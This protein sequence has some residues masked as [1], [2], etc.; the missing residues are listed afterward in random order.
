MSEGLLLQRG[1]AV[2]IAVPAPS[3][4]L[5]VRGR[6]TADPMQAAPKQRQSEGLFSSHDCVG[7]MSTIKP[8]ASRLCVLNNVCLD[9]SSG[10][11]NYYRD[12]QATQAPIVFDRRYGHIFAFGHVAP[13][14]GREDLL[15]LN[16]HVRYKRHVRW[17]PRI[18]DGPL[19][20]GAQHL[21]PLHLLS[22]PFVSTNLGHLAWE[23]AF[24]LLLGMAQLGIYEEAP[25]ILRTHDCNESLAASTHEGYSGRRQIRDVSNGPTASEAKL[26][27]KFLEGFMKPL[28][29]VRTVG[30]VRAEYTAAGT[31]HV[32]FTRLMAGGYYDMFNA[33]AHAGKEPWLQLYRQRVL[34]HH[35]L[36]PPRGLPPPPSTHSLLLV[37]KDGRRGIHNYDEVLD[38]IRHGCGGVCTGIPRTVPVAFHTMSM[39]DQLRAVS[40]TT[41]A[42]SPP[43][44]VSMILPFM[45][46]GSH[47]IL[48]NYMLGRS[49]T[50]S[51]AHHLR[52]AEGICARCS[53]TMEAS[54]W[55]HVRHVRKLYYQVWEGSDFARGVPGRDAAVIIKLPRLAYLLRVALDAMI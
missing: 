54:L 25:V 40:T 42:V 10:N 43:G 16:K 6:G 18:V 20:H 1:P 7:D 4:T 23:E 27:N 50:G 22:A 26:C 17:S 37:H 55:R 41:I 12:P 11:F 5:H 53:L 14:G 31:R 51:S 13:K 47:A 35:K 15:P 46:E 45:P 24:P 30:G 21:R 32:C 49:V 9:T 3:H 34:S 29:R 2:H 33:P 28:G 44:G 19:P 36:A 52:G 38:F 8:R 48:I 39:V